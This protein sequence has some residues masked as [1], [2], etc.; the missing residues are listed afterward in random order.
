[1]SISELNTKV[2]KDIEGKDSSLFS[3]ENRAVSYEKECETEQILLEHLLKKQAKLKKLQKENR[4]LEKESKKIEKSRL[5]K[6]VSPFWK[7]VDSMN[8]WFSFIPVN[9]KLTKTIQENERLKEENRKLLERLNSTNNDSFLQTTITRGQLQD[10]RQLFH[11]LK[12]AKEDGTFVDCLD[13]MIHSKKTIDEQ[14][15]EAL[16][17]A[18]KL[19]KNERP[20]LKHFVYNKVIQAL[21]VETVPEFLLRERDVSLKSLAS[22]R[23]S[24]SRQSRKEQLGERLPEMVLDDKRTA[25]RFIDSLGIRRPWVSNQSYSY[26]DLPEENGVVIKPVE[27]AGSRGVYLVYAEDYIQDVRRGE[28]LRDRHTL[29]LRMKQDLETGWVKKDAWMVEELII[30]NQS[31]KTAPRDLKFYCYYGEIALILEIERYPELK[32]CWRTPDG[33]FI[34]T[35]KYEDDL[36]VGAGFTKEDLEL[37]KKISLEIPAPFMRIDFLKTDTELVFGEFTPRPGNYD[38]F[39]QP[40]DQWL[41]DCY[42]RAEN[43]LFE[44]LVNGKLFSAYNQLIELPENVT[45]ISKNYEWM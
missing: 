35:G 15:S 26:L 40:I 9:R 11:R 39:D 3:K 33:N 22:F 6:F 41:G 31:S 12:E 32:Y 24:L 23:G 27:G 7:I 43:R 8:K 34:H 19:Y 30:G 13:T 2:K 16:K 45:N 25:Y 5:W 14:Y 18:A 20:E 29:T 21:Q 36:F 17:Y 1:M 4:F 44:D 37:A 28:I 38:E 10:S 42:L